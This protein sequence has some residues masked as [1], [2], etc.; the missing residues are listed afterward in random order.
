MTEA[1]ALTREVISDLKDHFYLDTSDTYKSN[2]EAWQDLSG[3]LWSTTVNSRTYPGAPAGSAFQHEPQD[4]RVQLNGAA[5]RAHRVVMALVDPN[6]MD[7]QHMCIDHIGANTAL[8]D[9]RNLP[10]N[11]R[12]L[13]VRQNTRVANK[14]NLGGGLAL[15]AVNCGRTLSFRCR[16]GTTNQTVVGASLTLKKAGIPTTSVEAALKY[17]DAIMK[18]DVVQDLHDKLLRWSNEGGVVKLTIEDTILT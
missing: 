14:T 8:R 12:W 15:V 18:L 11:L 4:W 16:L 9:F 5:I 2:H 7:M 17:R 3:L 6:Y 1:V 13:T 10:Q